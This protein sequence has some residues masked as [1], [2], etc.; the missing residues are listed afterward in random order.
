VKTA[1]TGI[2]IFAHAE[3]FWV[4]PAKNTV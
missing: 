4:F 2:S 3:G 1:K